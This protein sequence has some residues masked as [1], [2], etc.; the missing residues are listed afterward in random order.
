M[1]SYALIDFRQLVWSWYNEFLPTIASD[2]SGFVEDAGIVYVNGVS[3]SSSKRQTLKFMLSKVMELKENGVVN[4]FAQEPKPVNNIL[5]H[6]MLKMVSESSEIHEDKKTRI[7]HLSNSRYVLLSKDVVVSQ[8]KEIDTFM[9]E[10]FNDLTKLT[11]PN[12]R[13][14]NLT[15]LDFKECVNVA[16]SFF[17]KS[18]L[19]EQGFSMGTSPIGVESSNFIL[20]N[21]STQLMR[22]FPTDCATLRV[23]GKCRDSLMTDLESLL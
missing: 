5:L 15:S 7:L 13:F 8:E 19:R 9:G 6:P 3:I 14:L 2:K 1:A 10:V 18:M 12:A 21:I 17:P 23:V 20:R 22:D 4:I 11:V 16:T